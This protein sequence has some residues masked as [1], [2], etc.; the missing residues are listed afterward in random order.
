MEPVGGGYRVDTPADLGRLIRQ[1]RDRFGMTQLELADAAG[2]GRRF[3][4]DLEAGK[5]TVEF[6]RALSVCAVLDLNLFAT[7]S[8]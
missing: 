5:P 3:I 2:T 7:A 1:A 8:S 4:S 6:G